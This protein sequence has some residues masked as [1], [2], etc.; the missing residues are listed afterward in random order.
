MPYFILQRNRW[1][2]YPCTFS[3]RNLGGAAELQWRR[4]NLGVTLLLG[5]ASSGRGG[6]APSS[7]SRGQHQAARA[8]TAPCWAEFR[9]RAGADS[10]QQDDGRLLGGP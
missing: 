8:M 10:V 4:S 1:K 5:L 3:R 2:K 9:G 7:A 6:A